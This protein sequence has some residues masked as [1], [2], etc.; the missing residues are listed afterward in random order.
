MTAD[1]TATVRLEMDAGLLAELLRRGELHASD[2]RCLDGSSKRCVRQLCKYSA[3]CS[4]ASCPLSDGGDLGFS[5]V[6][7]GCK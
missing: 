6:T 3:A 5:C 1:L 7:T 2:F 4:H